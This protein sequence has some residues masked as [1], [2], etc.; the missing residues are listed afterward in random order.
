VP[1]MVSLVAAYSIS[2][3]NRCDEMPG[4]SLLIDAIVPAIPADMC[5][6]TGINAH[7]KVSVHLLFCNLTG[8]HTR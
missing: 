6:P 2:C 7:K 5:S 3:G 1:E 4:L 8:Y